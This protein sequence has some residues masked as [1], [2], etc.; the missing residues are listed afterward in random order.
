M[1][2]NGSSLVEDTLQPVLVSFYLRFFFYLR[3]HIPRTEIL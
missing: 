1:V 2:S 3:N